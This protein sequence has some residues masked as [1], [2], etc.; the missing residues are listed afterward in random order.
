MEQLD[1]LDNSFASLPGDTG[2]EAE[3]AEKEEVAPAPV[4]HV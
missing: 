4:V 2:A 3:P 1:N